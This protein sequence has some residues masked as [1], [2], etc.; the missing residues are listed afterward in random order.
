MEKI[1]SVSW[2]AVCLFLFIMISALSPP[3]QN[4]QGGVYHLVKKNETIWSI[5]RAYG[6]PVKE[7]A[8]VNDI[9]DMNS[10]KE[11]SVLFIPSACQ[12]ID[13]AED[14]GIFNNQGS[15][16]DHKSRV[17]GVQNIPMEEKLKKEKSLTITKNLK[18]EDADESGA[19]KMRSQKSSD[20]KEEPKHKTSVPEKAVGAGSNV[21][22]WPVR[23]EVKACFG[24]QP[25][26][27]FNNWIK[28]VS[29]AGK[30]IKAAESGTVIF[31]SDLKNYGETIIIKHKNDFATVYT[32]VKKRLVTIDKNVKKGEPIAILGEKDDAGH[33][34]MN[35]EIRVKGKA[36]NPLV[37]LP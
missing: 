11:E 1:T 33:V 22:I 4:A 32:H 15:R 20:Q 24:V 3:I 29:S 8:K 26:K 10:I 23:G 25:N 2:A 37:F 16:G 5:A 14:T 19:A 17:N 34:Y 12:V 31:S 27:T 21:F 7:L 18:K 9:I 6:I 36:Q 28:I 30:K 13:N 35:F